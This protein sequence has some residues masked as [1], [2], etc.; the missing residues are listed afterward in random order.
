MARFDKRESGRQRQAR[1]D[2]Q[3]GIKGFGYVTGSIDTR[4]VERMMNRLIDLN[5]KEGTKA[6]KHACRMA[7]EVIDQET[8]DQA[9]SLKLNSTMRKKGWRKT[10]KTRT[11]FAYKLRRVKSKS[12]WFYSAVNYK[13]PMLRISHLVEKGFKHVFAGFVPGN[14]YRKTAF[15]Q[16]RT[17]ALKVLELNLLYGLDMIRRGNKVP[18]IT[19]W[20][21]GAPR[22]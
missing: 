21:K 10:L 13:K 1:R 2:R 22:G 7:L 17:K 11:A 15:R 12:F 14:W 8:V 4:D 16:K 20:R 3:A 18:N 19:Q 6:V 9:L 5:K